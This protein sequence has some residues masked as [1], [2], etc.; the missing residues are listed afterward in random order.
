M[1]LVSTCN[2][3][4]GLNT[5]SVSSHVL[6]TPITR[7]WDKWNLFLLLSRLGMSGEYKYHDGCLVLLNKYKLNTL[8]LAAKK[9]QQETSK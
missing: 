7:D 6:K 1:Y 4:D 2:D 8:V 5:V 9:G 3:I